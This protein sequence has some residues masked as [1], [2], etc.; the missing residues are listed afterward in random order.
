M[1]KQP[2]PKPQ[3]PAAAAAPP[4]AAKKRKAN[5]GPYEVDAIIGER[6]SGKKTEFRIR[7][8]GYEESEATWEPLAA[9]GDCPVV[10]I[11]WRMKNPAPNRAA[12]AAA[13]VAA[14]AAAVG[15][16]GIS[17]VGSAGAAVGSAGA[18]AAGV[19]AGAVGSAASA[20]ASAAGSAAGSAA[21]A[22]AV[23]ARY[24]HMIRRRGPTVGPA[25]ERSRRLGSEGRNL[26]ALPVSGPETAT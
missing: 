8:K 12:R 24:M 20:T 17:A 23:A 3:Q 16:T 15:A 14:G 19:T 22:A 10:L 6:V 13:A 25:A 4:P 7:W 11:A 2:R 18:A 1:Q 21:R 9:L 5:D 26:T